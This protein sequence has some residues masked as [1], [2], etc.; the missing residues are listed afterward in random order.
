M[1]SRLWHDFQILK[2]AKGGL[3]LQENPD[4]PVVNARVPSAVSQGRTQHVTTRISIFSYQL[5]GH[6]MLGCIR[7]R[8]LIQT[9][10]LPR[11]SAKTQ[12]GHQNDFPH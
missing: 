3:H 12:K 5:F 4:T 11:S 1:P 6:F 7:L 8:F 10:F 2:H 9:D